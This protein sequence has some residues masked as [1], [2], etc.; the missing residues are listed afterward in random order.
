[1]NYW[2]ILLPFISASI[3]WFVNAL[4]IKLMFH[5]TLPVN[6]LGIRF[7]GVLPNRQHQLSETL[8]QLVAER[9]VSFDEIRSRVTNPE[10]LKDILPHVEG[11]IDEFLRVRLSR[12]MPMISMFI[13]DKTINQLK[14]IFMDELQIIF[15]QVLNEYMNNLQQQIDVKQ[16]I[17]AKLTALSTDK[18]E[19]SLQHLMSREFW[20]IKLFGAVLGFLIGIIQLLITSIAA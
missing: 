11:H 2:L 8:G 17:T 12:Q 13:G 5:P 10:N 20:M 9:F 16:T 15:P 19:Q 14:A 7:Q 6:I 4:A 1:M 18:I 3:G